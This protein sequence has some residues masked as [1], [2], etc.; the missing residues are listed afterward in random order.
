[1]IGVELPCLTF[2][3]PEL[4]GVEGTFSFIVFK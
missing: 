4:Y 1:M 2:R 3:L